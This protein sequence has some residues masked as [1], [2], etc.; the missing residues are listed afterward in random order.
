MC[1]SVC[2]DVWVSVC[3]CAFMCL[4]VSACLCMFVYLVVR[5]CVALPSVR[6]CVPVRLCVCVSV[7]VR[8]HVRNAMYLF[9]LP[10]QI[11]SKPPPQISAGVAFSDNR[12]FVGWKHCNFTCLHVV[13]LHFAFLLQE[14]VVF[15]FQVPAQ[16]VCKLRVQT[17]LDV[18]G[19]VCVCVR[20]CL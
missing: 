5:L 8:V 3:V 10:L 9:E 6:V 11:E 18:E 17:Y 14:Y 13:V 2:L 12:C 20:V 4:C 16:E 1:V 19:V 15:H 7:L